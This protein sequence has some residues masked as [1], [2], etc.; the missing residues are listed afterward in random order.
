MPTVSISTPSG[1]RHERKLRTRQALLE[2]ALRL[3]ERRSF[4]S[5]SLREVAREAGVVPGTFY[6]HF[7]SMEEL[8][9]ELINESFRTPHQTLRSARTG[10]QL[11]EG[12]IRRSVQILARHVHEHESHFR[13]IARERLCG[14]AAMR[15]AISNEIRIITSEL[16]V[17]LS[18]SRYLNHWTTEDLHMAA[19]VFVN[20]MFS[21][22]EQILDAP[23]DDPDAQA[24]LVRGAEQQLRL[25]ALGVTQWKSG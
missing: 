16:A 9:P 6:R 3:H 19:G 24:Q 13:F 1:S 5:L 8:G 7:K 21:I 25:I 2:S 12:V 11:S 14:D 22:V 4:D 17:D 20:A 18:R 10:A 23:P 15:Q